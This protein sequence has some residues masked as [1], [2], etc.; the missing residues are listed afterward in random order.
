[1]LSSTSSI[2]NPSASKRK[3]IEVEIPWYHPRDKDGYEESDTEDEGD[4]KDDDDYFYYQEEDEKDIEEGEGSRESES[5]KKKNKKGKEK[6][7]ADWEQ[8]CNESRISM[9]GKDRGRFE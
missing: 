2:K 7:R 4:D 3:F 9:S 6:A 8:E 5:A 1:M